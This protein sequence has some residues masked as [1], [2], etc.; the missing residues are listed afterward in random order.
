M[1]KK[2]VWNVIKALALCVFCILMF[3]LCLRI[4][5]IDV[6]NQKRYELP[7]GPSVKVHQSD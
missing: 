3:Y 2:E 6:F 5:Q 7:D 1:P 4:L